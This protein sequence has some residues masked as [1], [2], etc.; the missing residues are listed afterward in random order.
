MKFLRP[1]QF[2]P[3]GSEGSGL[4][5]WVIAVMV[6]LLTLSA[7]FGMMLRNATGDWTASLSHTLTVQIVDTD[8]QE[9]QRQQQAAVAALI[10]TPGII[11][12]TPMQQNEVFALLEPWLGTGNLTDELPV[13]AMISVTLNPD[14]TQN[15]DALRARVQAVAPGARLD[16][17]QQWVGQVVTLSRA[18]ELSAATVALLIAI[19]TI[20]LV[21]FATQARLSSWR[22]TV[23]LVHLLGA[24]DRVIAGEFQ[25]RF[26]KWGLKGGL[27]GFA[28][29]CLVLWAFG[30]LAND[31]A[32]GLIP[33]LS[34]S[35]WQ[36]ILLAFLPF[37]SALLSM[38]SANI[39]VQR[40]LS[41]R[42]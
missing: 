29:G 10:T 37:L 19:A 22:D 25:L 9:R 8:V 21:I 7:A 41:Q 5:P 13:P 32:D 4:M 16:D 11:D 6:F 3:S 33:M 27:I 12:A 23:Y 20:I 30:S 17:H 38:V 39:T 35:G 2:L 14:Y 26:F 24:E 31:M 28:L 40:T 34:L 42:I 15:I 18:A 36:F 1:V